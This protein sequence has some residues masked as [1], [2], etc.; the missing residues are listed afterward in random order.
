MLKYILRIIQ[1]DKLASNAMLI[2]KNL[3]I[4]IGC[5]SILIGL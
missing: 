2:D 3:K 5:I 4:R 1:L